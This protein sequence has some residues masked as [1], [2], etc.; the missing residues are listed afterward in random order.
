ME[1]AKIEVYTSPTCPYCPSAVKLVNRV[2]KGRND[3]KVS[4]VN[5]ATS[6]GSRRAK[7]FGIMSVPTVLVTGPATNEIIG[8]RGTP[9][10]KKLL[11]AIDIALGK[12]SVKNEKEGLLSRLIGAIKR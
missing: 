11:E 4:V 6:K 3:V 2:A 9:S 10:E 8:F 1:K 12:S 5:T 7:K